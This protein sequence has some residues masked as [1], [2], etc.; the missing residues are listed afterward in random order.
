MILVTGPT[1]S[2]KT[3]TL[4]AG[5]QEINDPS[6]NITTIEDPI[7]Y[8]LTGVNQT[9]VKKDIGLTF[10]ASLRS[11]LRQDPNVIMVGEI[12]DRD[13]SG[14]N[15]PCRAFDAS[16]ERCPL[17]SDQARRYGG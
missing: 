10:A 15:R 3:T 17:G 5:L 1:G 4:Y 13:P 6:V 12:R 7:E 2:G 14:L 11:I 9:H 16:Y 8:N